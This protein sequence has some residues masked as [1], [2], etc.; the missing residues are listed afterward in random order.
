[1]SRRALHVGSIL[2]WITASLYGGVLT[3]ASAAPYSGAG[4]VAKETPT[5]AHLALLLPTGSD[6]FAKPAEAVRGGFLDAAKKDAGAQLPI[7]LYPVSDD[8]QSVLAAY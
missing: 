5:S 1:M 3:H 2:L 6:A 4:E 7:R 8:P